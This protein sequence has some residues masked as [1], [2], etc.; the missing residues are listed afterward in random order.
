MSDDKRTF[1]AGAPFS[2]TLEGKIAALEKERDQLREV[3]IEL[4]AALQLCKNTLEGHLDEPQA[5]S[6]AECR[7]AAIVAGNA[8]ADWENK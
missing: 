2:Q 1:T 5:V 4:A 3:G 7:N 6:H 8:L